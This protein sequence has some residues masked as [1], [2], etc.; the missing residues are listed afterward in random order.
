M[1]YES[2]KNHAYIDNQ[3]I[4]IINSDGCNLQEEIKKS[5]IMQLEKV[6]IQHQSSLK[7]L[8]LK[9]KFVFSDKFKKSQL[10]KEF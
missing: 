6:L 10:E 4:I 9:E 3:E 8:N 5:E 1:D 2:K 7:E